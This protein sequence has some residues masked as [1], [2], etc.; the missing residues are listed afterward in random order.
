MTK[1]TSHIEHTTDDCFDTVRRVLINKFFALGK[2]YHGEMISE[3]PEIVELSTAID[4]CDEY[5]GGRR[6]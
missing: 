2:Q 4:V 1:T 3:V 5:L 6:G